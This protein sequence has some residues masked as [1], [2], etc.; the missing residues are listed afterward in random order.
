[1]LAHVAVN[2]SQG[3]L[4][5]AKIPE[6][7]PSTAYRGRALDPWHAAHDQAL[8]AGDLDYVTAGAPASIRA[9]AQGVRRDDS[10]DPGEFFSSARVSSGRI[11][12]D[13]FKELKGKSSVSRSTVRAGIL[14]CAARCEKAASRIGGDTPADGRTPGVAAGWSR[15]ELKW[16]VL[17]IRAC[18]WFFAAGK[19]VERR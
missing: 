9:R 6:F 11:A 1:M 18:C 3:M 5:L 10:L 2:P 12:P 4:H 17:A 13:H 19:A 15:G 8:I 16:G 14:F 7:S